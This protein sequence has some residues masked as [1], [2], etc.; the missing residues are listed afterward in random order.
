MSRKVA[1][2]PPASG[3][4]PRRATQAER[5][6]RTRKRLLDA[7][8]KVF[9]RRGYEGATLDEITE[10]AELSKGAVYYNFASKEELFLTLLEERLVERLG[11][12]ERVFERDDAPQRQSSDAAQQF[13]ENLEHDPRWAPLFFEFLA[14]CA[15]DPSRRAHFAERFL[16][17]TRRLL[18]GVIQQRYASLDADPPMAPEE[19]AT[20]IAALTNGMVIERLFDPRGVREDLLGR[21]V[22]LLT[23]PLRS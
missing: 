15:R 4:R 12:V 13:L 17:A 9:A 5:R 2:P 23:R 19:L 10:V 11:D 22:S 8:G 21:G 7:A 20:C 16:R 14:Y 3:R 6:S 1:T 18:A